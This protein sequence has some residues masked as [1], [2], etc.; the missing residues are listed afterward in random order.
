L[1]ALLRTLLACVALVVPIAATAGDC[2]APDLG[3]AASGGPWKPLAFSPFKRD[4]V[5]ALVEDDGRTVLRGVAVM[6]DTD[7]T[8][9]KATGYYADL[10]IECA[11]D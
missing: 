4:T 6:T 7:N 3:F 2:A 1:T 8:G 11:T 5:Y 9:A 10:R